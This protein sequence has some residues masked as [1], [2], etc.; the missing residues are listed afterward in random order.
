MALSIGEAAIGCYALAALL[1]LGLERRLGRIAGRAEWDPAM[2]RALRLALL[3][4]TAW[5]CATLCLYLWPGPLWYGV[6][7]VLDA[8][9]YGSWFLML[10]RLLEPRRWLREF[11]RAL[12]VVTAALPLLVLVGWPLSNLATTLVLALPVLGMF[13]VEQFYRNAAE[14]Q[15]WT[16]KPMCIGLGAVFVFDLYL[17]THGVLFGRLEP[18]TLVVR[19]AVHSLAVP[20]LALALRR[21]ALRPRAL[22]LSHSMAYHTLTLLLVGGYLLLISGA[23]YYVRKFSGDWG[24]ALQVGFGV[25]ALAALAVALSSGA[26][27]AHLRVFVS[28]HFF[29]YH[30]DY[31]TEWLRFTAALS[32]RPGDA[33]FGSQ[34]VRG[35]ADMVESP[36]GTLWTVVADGS[37]FAPSAYWNS[38]RCAASEAADSPFAR[39]MQQRD[40]LVE[41]QEL[42]DRP[43]RYD[44]LAAPAWLAQD[45]TAWVVVPLPMAQELIGFVVLAR[46]RTPLS[47]NWEL[48]DLL[49]TAGRQ[50]GIFIARMRAAEALLE[51]RKFEAFNRMSAFVVHDLKNIVTQLSLMMKNAKRLQHNPEFQADMLATVDNALEKMRQLM[52][53]LRE[54][55]APVDG[56]HGVDLEALARRL[57]HSVRARGR[58]LEV[59]VVQPV[60]ARGDEQRLERVVG[61]VVQNALDATPVDKRVW[62]RVERAVGQARIIVG[63]E[64]C[65]MTA[66]FIAN[67]LFKPFN[68]TKPAGMGIGAHESARY[69]REL[70]GSIAVRSE[71]GRGTEIT[72]LLPL[73]ET[74]RPGDAFIARAA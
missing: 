24:H 27:R 74:E 58:E 63:D 66:D 28:K 39:F 40:W 44:G 30:Y 68:T 13:L 14:D 37:H 51:A 54:G 26:V 22:Q 50:A 67:S 10:M 4:T 48:R 34:V 11:A 18:H 36:G 2:A 52:L 69:L 31:R 71:P 25:S 47:V 53:Q 5:A 17:H 23:G 55:E 41:L 43:E 19:A 42:R 65:G 70:G 56:R 15:R 59:E 57:Q 20:A 45:P 73:I 61:H 33:D 35:L 46:P 3:C 60:T 29:N 38:P 49:K 62:L 12:V 1:H 8:V 72:M 16:T 32:S 64:G 21:Q 7:Q 9:R 6:A